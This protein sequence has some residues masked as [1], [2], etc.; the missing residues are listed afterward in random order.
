[1]M[2]EVLKVCFYEQYFSNRYLCQKY[3]LKMMSHYLVAPTPTSEFD[4][5]SFF[6]IIGLMPL[7]FFSTRTVFLDKEGL[8]IAAQLIETVGR[9]ALQTAIADYLQSLFTVMAHS[10]DMPKF[11]KNCDGILKGISSMLLILEQTYEDPIIYWLLQTLEPCMASIDSALSS[12]YFASKLVDSKLHSLNLVLTQLYQY[13]SVKL[14]PRLRADVLLPR[15]SAILSRFVDNL[16][17]PLSRTD[18]LPSEQ[19]KINAAFGNLDTY[20]GLIKLGITMAH[21]HDGKS[22]ASIESFIDNLLQRALKITSPEAAPESAWGNYLL[23][24]VSLTALQ[25]VCQGYSD[26]IREMVKKGENHCFVPENLFAIGK[27][28]LKNLIDFKQQKRPNGKEDTTQD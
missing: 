14:L 5:S 8:S 16:L 28:V 1:M 20:V 27:V 6:C 22:E 9:D 11:G 21:F 23:Q 18:Q 24:H 2:R 15:I 3:V 4:W 17:A 19:D 7:E 10:L 25:G 13:G 12:T 26:G